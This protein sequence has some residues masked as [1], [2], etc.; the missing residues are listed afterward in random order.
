MAEAIAHYERALKTAPS[1]TE[2]HVNL[3]NALVQQGRFDEAMAHYRTALAIQPHNEEIYGNIGNAHCAQA[4]ALN[5][6]GRTRE[7][8]AHYR[9]ALQAL[10]ECAEALN[11]LA[12]ILAANA[13]PGVRNGP[14]AVELAE[15]ACRLAEYK[16]PLMVGTLAAA[17]AEAGRFAESRGDSGKGRY[18]SRSRPI[19]LQWRPGTGD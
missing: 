19:S 13:D 12:W 14:E 5:S 2:A 6:Q 10:P 15:H 4:G 18:C 17:Y 16:Q 7:S 9:A 11:N 3:G 1:H 8:I